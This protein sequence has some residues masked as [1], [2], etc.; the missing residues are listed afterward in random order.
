MHVPAAMILV[1]L[2]WFIRSYLGAGRLWLAWSITGLRVLVLIVNFSLPPNIIFD[3][4]YALNSVSFLGETLSAPVGDMNPWRFLIHLSMVLLLIY[5]LD[6]AIAA[7]K[8]GR[9]RQ[10]L[11]LAASIPVAIILA[12]TFAGLMVRGILPGPFVALVYL[13]LVFTMAFEL[14]VDLIRS[15]QLSR[16][17]Q[18]SEK[19]MRLAA[20]A[21]DLAL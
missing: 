11:V 12:A 21:A 18:D 14:S 4:I 15:K 16:E 13:T 1:A 10:S 8:L 3:E 19:R 20:R 6:A 9:G 7:R 2:V 5:V 17:L